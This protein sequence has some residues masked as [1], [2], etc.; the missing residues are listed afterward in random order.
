MVPRVRYDLSHLSMMTGLMGRVMSFSAI[1]IVAGDSMA[2]SLNGFMRLAPLRRDQV[3]DSRLDIAAFY[4]PYTHIYGDTWIRFIKSGSQE[5]ETLPTDTLSFATNCLGAGRLLGTVP[6]W[7]TRGYLQILERYYRIPDDSDNENIS[8]GTLSTNATD[9]RYGYP[10]PRLKSFASTG[11]SL[12]ASLA[13]AGTVDVDDA[14]D[15][16]NIIELAQAK[17]D[18][19]SQLI[20][21]W[22]AQ[23][24]T[25]VLNQKW[26][27]NVNIDA[28]QRPMLLMRKSQWLSG[29]DINGT[30]NTSLGQFSGK[31]HS[32]VQFDVPRRFYP[33]HGTLWILGVVR[34]PNI[35]LNEAH[36][37]IQHADPSYLDVSADPS[38]WNVEPPTEILQSDLFQG[39]NSNT[40]GVH[41]F[42]QHYRSH[43][44]LIHH[45]FQAFRGFPYI[46]DKP[47]LSGSGY[48]KK[49]WYV[50]SQDDYDDVFQTT[51]LGHWRSNFKISCVADRVV[52]SVGKSIFAGTR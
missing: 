37:L 44:N 28:D 25:D 49:A 30:D 16:F 15:T 51:Q 27:S 7:V 11:R 43:P 19:R 29:H 41:P 40:L 20:L 22:Q 2:I 46:R 1:P 13:S 45:D 50:Q 33:Q 21:Q 23:R 26:N 5:A 34:F 35:W 36:Y 38:L 18:L 9:R 17:G 14:S 3:V 12:D 10:A 48:N 4:I 31:V 39:G 47:D 52:P 32:L 6:R 42:G 24:Y 8:S